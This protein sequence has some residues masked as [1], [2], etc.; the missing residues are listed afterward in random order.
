VI[1]DIATESPELKENHLKVYKTEMGQQFYVWLLVMC[2]LNSL[3]LMFLGHLIIFHIELKYK[4]LSTYEFLRL[5][6]T[7]TKES[8]IVVRINK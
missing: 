7:V 2:V 1:Y 6:E 4:G 8:K 5:K 3:A